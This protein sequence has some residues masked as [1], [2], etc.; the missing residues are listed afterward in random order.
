[1]PALDSLQRGITDPGFAFL[2]ISE[3]VNRSEALR[4]VKEFG[5]TF[6]VAFGDGTLDRAFFYPGLPFTVLIDAQGRVVK[7]WIGELTRA[8]IG[9]LDLAIARELGARAE[10]LHAGH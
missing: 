3:D 1:M 10:P 2:A 4:L 6:P 8:D 7:T 9:R 5:F